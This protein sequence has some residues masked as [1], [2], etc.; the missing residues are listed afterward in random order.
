MKLFRLG[1]ASLLMMGGMASILPV[2]AADV[3]RLE[4]IIT[5]S[6]IKTHEF[7]DVTIKALDADG[8]VVTNYGQNNDGDIMMYLEEYG[9]KQESP[10]FILP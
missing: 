8:K 3:V 9:N 4:V 10:D 2:F 7:T 5:P 1:V 6:T